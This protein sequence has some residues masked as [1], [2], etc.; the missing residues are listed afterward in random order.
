M[1]S[2][3]DRPEQLLAAL[4]ARMAH[5]GIRGRHGRHFIEDRSRRSVIPASMSAY[6]SS[7]LDG[8]PALRE[9]TDNPL[10]EALRKHQPLPEV[11][12]CASR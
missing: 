12:G 5:T 10:I 6:G 7:L 8:E 4:E 1:I 2:A 9:L 3:W 11:R